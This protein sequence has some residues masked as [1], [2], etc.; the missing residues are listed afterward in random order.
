ML[1]WL[2]LAAGLVLLLG[3]GE[4]LVR[5]SVA[6]ATRLGVSPL[7]IGLTLVG[8]GTSTPELVASVEAALIGA[9]GIAVGNVV[10]SN[11]ANVLLIMG[12]AAVLLPMATTRAAFTRDGAVLVGA[13]LVMVGIV[14]G[15]SLERWGG[16]VLLVLLA[17]YSGYAYLTERG[18]GPAAELHAAEVAEVA[19]PRT[20]SLGA[21]AA[22]A[23]GG[24]AG[25][26]LGASL[27]VDSAIVIARDLGLSEAVIGLTLVAVGTSLPELAT[28]V[29]AALRRH[30]DVALGNVVGSNIFNILGIAGVTA[31][32]KPIPIPAEIVRFDVWVM[33]AAA[34][35]LVVFAVSGWRITRRE[36]AVLLAGYVAYLVVQF[37]PG[38]RGALGLA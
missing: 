38:V 10:G 36:G 7:L 1:T 20:L 14:L 28:A 33:L 16:A 8:F 4:F 2:E 6:V 31:L 32:V 11:I 18:G 12:V 25:V 26:V 5:G 13:T 15:G 37:A 24:I 21:A 27:L 17:A 30:G 29:M 22:L 35:L 3:G 23:L 34:L 19:V 9:P